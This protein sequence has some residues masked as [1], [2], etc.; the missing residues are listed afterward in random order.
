LLGPW[1][2]KTLASLAP[3]FD[4][5]DTRPVVIH[6]SGL[7]FPDLLSFKEW[8]EAG[9]ALAGAASSTAWCLGDWLVYGEATYGD[10]YREAVK[11]T[12]LDYQTLRNYAWVARS[13]S[14][15]RRR[16]RLSFAH[17]AEVAALPAP[18]QDYWLRKA[19][20]ESW[21]RNRIRRE[22][23]ESL[24]ERK[25]IVTES[26]PEIQENPDSSALRPAVS[27]AKSGQVSLSF[28]VSTEQMSTCQSAADLMG[29]S[30]ERWASWA[31]EN[32]ARHILAT[33]GVPSQLALGTE[34]CS[35]PA[36]RSGKLAARHKP[37]SYRKPT[38]P[39]RNS[40]LRGETEVS[41]V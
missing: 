11:Q 1:E 16:D 25:Q 23:R 2:P 30:L 6:R 13:F 12:S 37:E 34:R 3:D 35:A 19:E 21:S 36:T 9:M 26:D 24:R 27:K 5:Q 39:T 32:A 17:H 14:L 33:L 38:A 7:E 22:V 29:M 40:A 20:N 4:R 31:L 18:E 28:S 8:S 41:K 15:S 10:R